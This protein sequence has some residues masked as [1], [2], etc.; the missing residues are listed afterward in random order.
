MEGCQFR[1]HLFILGSSTC[2]CDQGQIL[3][4]VLILWKVS[5]KYSS[6]RHVNYKCTSKVQ[7]KTIVFIT[8]HKI[9]NW[10]INHQDLFF[11]CL[12]T[13]HKNLSAEMNCMKVAKVPSW[14]DLVWYK[15]LHP[16]PNSNA[17]FPCVQI[18]YLY[19]CKKVNT[20]QIST[21]DCRV[22]VVGHQD[23]APGR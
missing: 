14:S 23:V 6:G 9:S 3:K 19:E 13:S 15:Q 22:S 2:L 21:Y 1:N 18:T 7:A 12:L 20:M 5:K 11:L 8:N 16:L 17:S 10:I 4:T